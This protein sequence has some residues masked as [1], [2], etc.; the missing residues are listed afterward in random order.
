MKVV[1][2]LCAMLLA[3]VSFNAGHAYAALDC[4][5]LAVD[6]Y[7]TCMLPRDAVNAVSEKFENSFLLA[8]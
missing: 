6:D 5:V 1:I 3:V 7:M 4:E 8:Y 2:K